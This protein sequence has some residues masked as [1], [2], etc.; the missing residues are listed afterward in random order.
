MD[1]SS[2]SSP[3][4]S[5]SA[6]SYSETAS[7]Y[8]SARCA[9]SAFAFKEC[10]F[11]ASAPPLRSQAGGKAPPRAIRRRFEVACAVLVRTR[12]HAAALMVRGCSAGV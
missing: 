2:K 6:F 7:L 5:S 12:S 8:L 11:V 1:A 4:E 9:A 3:E 10:A